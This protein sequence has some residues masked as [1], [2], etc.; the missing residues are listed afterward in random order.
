MSER[1]CGLLG[2]KLGHSYSPELHALLGDYPYRLFEVAP[3]ALGDFLRAREFHG[4]NVTIPYKTVLADV[5]EELTES[6]A[7]IGS[8]N[9][10]VKRAD[11]TLLGDN[12]DAAGFEAMIRRAGLEIAGAKCLVFGSGGASRAVRYVLDK[13]GAGEIVVI[14]RTGEDNYDNLDRHADAQILVN[15]TPLGT[16]PDTAAAPVDLRDFPAC[17]GVLDLVYNPARTAL[18]QQAEALGVPCQGG[19]YMLVEQARC[20]AKVFFGE[21]IPLLR[22]ET[23]YEVLRA[24]KENRVLIGMPGCGKSTV[25]QA[26]ADLLDCPLVDADRELEKE[27]GMPCGE[28]ITRRGEAVFRAHETALLEKLGKESGLVI[29][30]GGGCVTRPENYPLLH[31]NGVMI[32]LERE[33]S[34]LP[35]KGRPLSQRGKLEDLY[36]IRLPMYRRFADCIVTNNGEPEDVAKAV[37]EAY[38]A[39]SRQRS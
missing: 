26:L 5:C 4:I 2:E 12:T 28:F 25:G 19:L 38:E 24:R 33:L 13:L 32:F 22:T 7:A 20:S 27:L 1:I 30:T 17:Q 37:E 39:F 21:G 31:Q 29:A 36:T 23:A 18:I 16:Y 8:V 10:V 14:S 9:T 6:A 15:A 3:Q 34:K 35:K 11:G